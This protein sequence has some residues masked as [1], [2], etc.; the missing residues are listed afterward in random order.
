MTT[1]NGSAAMPAPATGA[2]GDASSAGAHAGAARTA[3]VPATHNIPATARM[4]IVH[5]RSRSGAQDRG[6]YGRNLP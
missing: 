1:R 6:E 5:P 3:A 4:A 2:I